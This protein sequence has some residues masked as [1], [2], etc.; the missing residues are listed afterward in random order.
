MCSHSGSVAASLLTPLQYPIFQTAI[1]GR[2]SL[3][4]AWGSDEPNAST[5]IRRAGSLLEMQAQSPS[6]KDAIRAA[7]FR[8]GLIVGVFAMLRHLARRVVMILKL[9]DLVRNLDTALQTTHSKI[10]IFTITARYCAL[11]AFEDDWARFQRNRW[12]ALALVE[13]IGCW[14]YVSIRVGERGSDGLFMFVTGNTNT[15]GP[16]SGW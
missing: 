8:D 16:D 5:E 9:N 2:A 15:C 7:V 1:T 10:R 6:E 4:G 3:E 12:S 13:Y 14:W 11:A